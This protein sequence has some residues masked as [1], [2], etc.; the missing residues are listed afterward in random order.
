M[1]QV[2]R[3]WSADEL[4]LAFE[5]VKNGELSVNKAS[6]VYEIPRR[7]LREYIKK[8]SCTVKPLGRH[9]VLTFAEEEK[10]KER[11]FKLCEY[12][13][14]ITVK[15]LRVAVFDYAKEEG[16]NVPFNDDKKTAG[17]QLLNT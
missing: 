3:K 15:A 7:T 1:A 8:N 12:G 2:R 9:P 13:F 6:I 14:P 5:K 16:I 4:R 17:K 10:L 11:I